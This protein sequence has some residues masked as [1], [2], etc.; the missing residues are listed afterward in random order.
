MSEPPGAPAAAEAANA[1]PAAGGV[2]PPLAAAPAAGGVPPPPL[3]PPPAAARLLAGAR[4]GV[5]RLPLHALLGALCAGLVIGPRVS[6]VVVALSA[7]A[8][9]AL[10][11]R[12][13][14]ALGLAAALALGAGYAGLRTAALERTSLRPGTAVSAEATLRQPP[15]RSPFGASV[16][17]TI[18]GEPVLLRLGNPPPRGLDVGAIVAVRG[19]ARPPGDFARARRAVAE[20]R[21][22]EIRPTGRARGGVAGIVDGVRRN[23]QRALA[24]G[25]TPPVAALHRGMVLGDDSGLPDEVRE[26][27]RATGMT[28]LVA[29][30]G[31]NVALLAALALAITT[32][33][34]LGLTARWVAVI[35]LIVLYV[36]L[37]GGGPSI[38]RAGIM[39]VAAAVAVIAGRPASR[40]YALLLAVALT[41]LLDPRAVTDPGWQLSFAAVAALLLRA[42]A[43]SE[44]LQAR[45]VPPPLAIA[46]AVTAAASLATAPLIAAHFGRASPIALPANVLA[47]PLV[48]PV[49]W[50]GALAVLAEPFAPAAA[51]A[52]DALAAYPLA[53]L[54]ALG[55][56]GA[57]LPGA[58]L[59]AGPFTVALVCAAAV[60]AIER[61]ALLAALPRRHRPRAIIA[62]GTAAA[63]ACALLAAAVAARPGPPA[64]PPPGQL[65]VTFLDVGQ[66]D[67]TLAQAG[68]RA[69]LVDTGP[70]DGDV[71]ARL[72]DAGV[73]RLDLLVV[74]HAEDDHAG[75]AADVLRR[76]DVGAFLDG[77]DG[78]AR[79]A[80]QAAQ[81]A[82]ADRDVRIVAPD[83]GMVLRVGAMTL[84]LLHP[85]AEPA[86]RHAGAD[87]NERAI[88]AELDARGARVLLPADAE[89]PVTL[90]LHLTGPV[91]VLKVAHHGSADDGLPALLTA[92]R[93]R[94]AVICVGRR[95]PFGH[96]TPQALGA[97]RDVPTLLRT[98]R[99]GSVRLD[100]TDRGWE[101]RTQT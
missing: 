49:M 8:A 69:I 29:A 21:V 65:R 79:P 80:A 82:A 76:V 25:L 95:N 94:I 64:P 38:Q 81:H 78:V 48:A 86:A 62:A 88:V 39:G 84:R 6:A 98:D 99:D 63:A 74:T 83:A 37:A 5:A 47:A 11:P 35:G 33:L 18:R 68:G 4:G 75:G 71:V 85:R 58:Q 56:A 73:T 54:L 40:G 15:R 2:P 32:A 28:H 96:P 31:A 53:C 66:G 16:E 12:R 36:P 27:F 34:G 97:L 52:C 20:V 13:A 87:P 10:A 72:R 26:D 57:R 60:V 55:H 41:L 1:A 89:S 61:R 42:R 91:D 44:R 43:W 77:S 30:S 67:A 22:A 100:R 93:P 19:T 7:A 24:H 90:P 70:S 23:A 59:Q 92:V 17:A 9:A 45:G 14:L 51:T 101:V 46:T 3:T 50:L